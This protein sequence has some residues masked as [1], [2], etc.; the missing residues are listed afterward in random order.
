MNTT[1]E[2]SKQLEK[3]LKAQSDPTKASQMK[4]YMRNKFEFFGV[5]APLRKEIIRS[6]WKANKEFIKSNFRSIVGQLWEGNERELQML[7]MDILGRCEKNLI[8][9]DLDLIQKL[10]T[11]KPWWD[12]VDF[13]ASNSIGHIIKSNMGQQKRLC[14][15]MMNSNNLWLQRT[16]ILH[17]LKYKHQTNY[18]LLFNLILQTI[19]S[20]E[21]FINN[22]TGWALRQYSKYNPER[23]SKF[24]AQHQTKLSTLTIREGCKYLPNN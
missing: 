9:D 24:I 3:I 8:L 14:D 5:P 20:K 19:G 1:A 22:A 12:T 7:A 6:E 23:V 2:Y 13:L 15:S 10:I 16:A 21:F 4:A 11:T 17:Q 18:D